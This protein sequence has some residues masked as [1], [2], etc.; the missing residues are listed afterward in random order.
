MDAVFGLPDD[1]T[2]YDSYGN[3]KTDYVGTVN[4][5]LSLE[6]SGEGQNIEYQFVPGD[7]GSH[8]FLGVTMPQGS[9]EL[10][11]NASDGL[12]RYDGE[13]TLIG[14]RSGITIDP[15]WYGLAAVGLLLIFLVFLVL[16]KRRAG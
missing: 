9:G 7:A 4:L 3:V 10:Q 15:L 1:D 11:V 13:M 16:S 14:Q 6:G 2:A 8:L 5:S 12:V